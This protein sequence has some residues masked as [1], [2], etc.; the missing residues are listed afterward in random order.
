MT[1]AGFDKAQQGHLKAI[2][3]WREG[4]ATETRPASSIITRR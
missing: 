3:I 4:I 2:N 1:R